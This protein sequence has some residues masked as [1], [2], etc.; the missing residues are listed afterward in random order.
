MAIDYS[1]YCQ[2]LN[3]IACLAGCAAC[4]EMGTKYVYSNVAPL[5]HDFIKCFMWNSR[6]FFFSTG[7]NVD[8]TL[9]DVVRRN[10]CF[11]GAFSS[12]PVL[13]CIL[14]KCKKWNKIHLRTT[15]VNL[16]RKS[17]LRWWREKLLLP[18]FQEIFEGEP[19]P[20]NISWMITAVVIYY[21]IEILDCSTTRHKVTVVYRHK[22]FEP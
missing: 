19:Y 21:I 4:V 7:M 5:L 14:V 9:F 17:G 11:S 12:R 1:V 3:H 6:F 20:W 8:T 13:T 2:L 18:C 16:L 15:M 22:L 10:V